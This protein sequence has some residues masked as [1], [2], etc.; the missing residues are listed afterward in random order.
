MHAVKGVY[1]NGKISIQE[2][3][4]LKGP[5]PV[6][7]MFPGTGEPCSRPGI[8]LNRFSFRKSQELLATLDEP[9]ST[10]VIEERRN[11]E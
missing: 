5:V 11:E 8:D 6:I 2:E 1:D 9:L 7:I 4:R 10:A 3:I